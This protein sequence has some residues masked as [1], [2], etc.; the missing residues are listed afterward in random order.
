MEEGFL[1]FDMVPNQE[2][3]RKTE[4]VASQADNAQHQKSL[5][6]LSFV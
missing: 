5:G 4:F 1:T 2:I 3:T 6:A